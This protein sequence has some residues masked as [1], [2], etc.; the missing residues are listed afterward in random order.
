MEEGGPVE[1]GSQDR[2]GR[3]DS[4]GEGRVGRAVLPQVGGSDQQRGPVGGLQQ[5]VEA[6]VVLVREAVRVACGGA[7]RLGEAQAEPGRRVGRGAGVPGGEPVGEAG[8]SGGEPAVAGVQSGE[9]GSHGAVGGRWRRPGEGGP[10]F[11]VGQRVEGV[12]E[13]GVGGAAARGAGRF[14]GEGGGR[15]SGGEGGG[16]RAVGGLRGGLPAGVRAVVLLADDRQDAAAPGQ[17]PGEVVD[18]GEPA[19]CGP[20]GDLDG[21]SA[22]VGLA[23]R[24][25]GVR[26]EEFAEQ[27]RGVRS[28]E[29]ERGHPPGGEDGALPD[30][31]DRELRG[32][33]GRSAQRG[34]ME[35]DPA[36]GGLAGQPAGARAEAG[37]EPGCGV[38]GAGVRVGGGPAGRTQ[39]GG[40]VVAV[41]GGVLG[42]EREPAAAQPVRV[43][44][45][46]GAPS[47]VGRFSP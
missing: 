2:F 37:E 17:P 33:G 34:E 10:H 35:G 4:A 18:G 44:R 5:Q 24:G 20:V 19:Q 41:R 30:G 6:P 47:A 25:R 16:L 26:V 15:A 13:Q 27:L 38:G 1:F 11:E 9:P 29:D 40:A 31:A 12:G 46:H 14:G 28:G 32:R 36:L 42:P 3:V 7:E 39:G 45:V 43:E 8:R 22:A 23:E 21:R